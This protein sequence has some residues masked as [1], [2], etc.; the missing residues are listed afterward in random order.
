MLKGDIVR[1]IL[2]TNV[3]AM[4]ELN[5]TKN[6]VGSAMAGSVGGFNAHASNIVTACFLAAGQDPAQNVESSTCIVLMDK[7]NDGKDLHVSVTM[8]SL[9]V[10]TV[11]G[12]TSL[13]AQAACL[14]ML[15]VKGS[16]ANPGD[17]ARQLARIFAA[18]VMAGEIS[19]AA[20]LTSGHLIAAHMA[21][22]RK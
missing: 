20:A 14:E 21:L 8:P 18:T 2:K 6:L 11:G 17:N 16:G 12:G 10:G 3:D 15:G 13:A 1:D 5:V 9:E 22:N 7:V 19:L 4:A